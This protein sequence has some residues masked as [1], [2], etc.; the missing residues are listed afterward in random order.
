MPSQRSNTPRLARCRP[1]DREMPFSSH[2][3]FP[4]WF[5]SPDWLLVGDRSCRRFGEQTCT[6][7]ART[8]FSFASHSHCRLGELCLDKSPIPR[9]S[10]APVHVQ[11]PRTSCRSLRS[12]QT[13]LN[14]L[15]K[16][17]PG[18]PV[19]GLAEGGGLF[20]RFERFER[21]DRGAAACVCA[22]PR[23]IEAWKSLFA[24]R[25]KIQLTPRFFRP[26]RVPG[27]YRVRTALAGMCGGWWW[28]KAAGLDA[29][30]N[31][32]PSLCRK[33]EFHLFYSVVDAMLSGGCVVT[34]AGARRL[35]RGRLRE[36]RFAVRGGRPGLLGED[37][38]GDG[39][40]RGQRSGRALGF[41]LGCSHSAI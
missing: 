34:R 11:N 31:G 18:W 17:E 19:G 40:M 7:S 2:P 28:R 22:R 23:S 14:P 13:L 3:W 4:S 10:L 27:D 36:D 20:E 29:A 25:F 5:H 33:L 9:H 35:R 30:D 15:C 38:C 12:F 37:C 32:G 26:S 21:L 1:S 39:G 6:K 24:Q 16:V 41:G 8:E